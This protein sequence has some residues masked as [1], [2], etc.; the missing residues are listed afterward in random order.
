[1]LF[2]KLP[3][4]NLDYDG[5]AWKIFDAEPQNKLYLL[6]RDKKK[7]KFYKK[8]SQLFQKSKKWAKLKHQC[9]SRGQLMLKIHH[10][11]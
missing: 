4:P 1:M 2:Q 3:L 10:L 9:C 11:H 5:E 8:V 7:K 6:E